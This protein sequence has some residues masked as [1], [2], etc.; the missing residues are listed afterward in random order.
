VIDKFHQDGIDCYFTYTP[1]STSMKL[2]QSTGNPDT[3]T[4]SVVSVAEPIRAS[5]LKDIRAKSAIIDTSF[6]G[7]VGKDVIY[8]LREKMS[9]SGRRARICACVKRANSSLRK[10]ERNVGNI[11]FPGCVEE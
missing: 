10:M 3:R 1:H 2:E 7:G 11:T 9:S 6:R 5:E 4:L 8:A